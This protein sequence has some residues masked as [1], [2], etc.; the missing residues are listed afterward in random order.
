MPARTVVIT[1]LQKPSGV[2]SKYENTVVTRNVTTNEFQQMA[3]R[4]GRRGIDNIGNVVIL[5]NEEPETFDFALHLATAVPDEIKSNFKPSYSLMLNILNNHGSF[6]HL[7]E[8]NDRS[9][10]VDGFEAEEKEAL[11]SYF[12]SGTAVAR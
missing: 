6:D 8:V 12:Q 11:S 10:A 7:N 5:G 9:F 4:A 1:S 3:G 2:K